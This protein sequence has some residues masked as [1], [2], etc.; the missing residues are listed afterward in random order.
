MTTAGGGG[1]N[2]VAVISQTNADG[3]I[4]AIDILNHGNGFALDLRPSVAVND[5]KCMCNLEVL[6]C[7][8]KTKFMSIIYHGVLIQTIDSS[9]ILLVWVSHTDPQKKPTY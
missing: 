7:G 9:T 2:F 8:C 1:S 3:A 6:G 5:P 4:L